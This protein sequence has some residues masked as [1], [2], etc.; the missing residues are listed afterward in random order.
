M[1]NFNNINQILDFAINAEQE[2]VDFYNKL[3]TMAKTEE[4]KKAF[5]EFA[6]EEVQHKIKLMKLK[7]DGIA[8]I[9]AE[10]VKTLNISDYL[11]KVKPSE[12]MNYQEALLLAMNKEKAAFKLYTSLSE[13]ATNNEMK[14][15]FSLLAM[16][17]SKHKLKFEIEYD[18]NVLREN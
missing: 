10:Q 13:K 1:V 9:P 16:E 18:D 15:L 11:V 3:A 8:D 17:E 7:E 14:K 6:R 5:E 4:I 2:A 12:E